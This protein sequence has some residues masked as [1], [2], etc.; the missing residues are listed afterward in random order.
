VT[1]TEWLGWLAFA[2]FVD[3]SLSNSP[4]GSPGATTAMLRDYIRGIVKDFSTEISFDFPDVPGPAIGSTTSTPKTPLDGPNITNQF[5]NKQ[6][7]KKFKHA[8]DF[9]I[10]GNYNKANAQ[11]FETA[12]R[13]QINSPATQVIRGTYRGKN[14]IHYVDLKTG[15][16]VI[17]DRAGNFISGWKL[18]PAQLNNVLTR[19]SL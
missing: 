9:G 19:G 7:Q 1:R 4:N 5:S 17:T 3:L 2:A 18:N 13:N 8:G 10:K 11:A 16:N 6:L 12:L 15:L 14:V